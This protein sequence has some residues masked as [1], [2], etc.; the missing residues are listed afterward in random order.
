[1]YRKPRPV[2]IASAAE[3]RGFWGNILFTAKKRRGSALEGP[4]AV[5]AEERGKRD[6]RVENGALVMGEEIK[7]NS[8]VVFGKGAEMG[9][10]MT[11]IIEVAGCFENTEK[12]LRLGL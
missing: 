10:R 9:W 7:L 1:M 4:D 11:A 8:R 3:H 5:G 2:A 12:R 6:S